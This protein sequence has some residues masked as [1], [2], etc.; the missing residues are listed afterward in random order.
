MAELD[1]G[2]Y[3]GRFL[4]DSSG[5]TIGTIEDVYLDSETDQAEWA[6]VNTGLHGTR[7]SFVPLRD[8]VAVGDGDVRVPVPREKMEQAAS[9]EP[10]GELSSEEE[11][12]LFA[13]YG[14][15][16]TESHSGAHSDDQRAAGTAGE[17]GGHLRLRRYIVT[18]HVPVTIPVQHEEV[19][20]ERDD[21]LRP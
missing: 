16:L 1:A 13:H 17:V 8:G 21:E 3:R 20:L 18:E 4:C 2:D 11:T 12:Q 7:G 9:I 6:V 5:E 15:D 19:R 10:G 14:L